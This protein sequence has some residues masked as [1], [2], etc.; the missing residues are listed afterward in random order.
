MDTKDYPTDEELEAIR[1]WDITAQPITG[2]LDLIHQ[3]WHWADGPGWHGYDL[4]GKKVLKLELSTGGW[5]GNEEIINA[6]QE[7]FM[8]W[9]LYWVSSHRGGHYYFRIPLKEWKRI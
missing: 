4:T 2:L 8:F 6:L 5:S 9:N 1:S 3:C 7:N